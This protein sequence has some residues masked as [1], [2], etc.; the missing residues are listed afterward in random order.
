MS[1]KKLFAASEIIMLGI[2]QH[3]SWELDWWSGGLII[4][5]C[6][7]SWAVQEREGNLSHNTVYQ[8]HPDEAFSLLKKSIR[9]LRAFLLSSNFSFLSQRVET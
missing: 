6:T 4:S 9:A 1:I 2:Y 3:E 5:G 7:I 8:Y